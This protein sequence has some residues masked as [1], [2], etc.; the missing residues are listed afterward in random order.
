VQ[1]LANY[2]HARVAF[3][4]AMGTTLETNHV[5][6]DEAMEGKISRPST[7]PAELPQEPAVNQGAAK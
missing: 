1:A 4:Q 5:S 2:T 3:E 7:L 6:V